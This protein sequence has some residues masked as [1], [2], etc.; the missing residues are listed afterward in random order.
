MSDLIDGRN[1][2]LTLDEIKEEL[3]YYDLRNPDVVGTYGM[4]KEELKEDGYGNHA[5]KD[6]SCDNCFYGRT[7][8]A[9][10]LLR[11]YYMVNVGNR[12]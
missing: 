8:M 4:T 12:T 11:Y 10:E 9:E 6:C 1:V 2:M 3:C 7:K 5:K